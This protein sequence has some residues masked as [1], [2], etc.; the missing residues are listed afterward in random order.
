V[1]EPKTF[2]KNVRKLEAGTIEIFGLTNKYHSRNQYWRLEDFKQTNVDDAASVLRAKLDEVGALLVRADVP[3]GIALS[4]GVDSGIIAAITKNHGKDIQAFTVG[5]TGSHACDESDDA[6]R[7][8]RTLGITPHV[9]KLDPIQVG[10]KFASLCLLRDEPVADI[11]GAG[12]LAV[13][14]FARENGV[15][16]LLNG[17]GADELFWGYAW[18]RD[19][20]RKSNRRAKLLY[21]S[22]NFLS[23]F[24]PDMPPKGKGAFI[25]WVKSGAGLFENLKQL[26]E[27]LSDRRLGNREVLVYKRGPRARAK[28]RIIKTLVAKE[29]NKDY[30]KK[31]LLNSEVEVSDQVIHT[32]LETYLRSNGLGQM[33]R[34][35]MA[36]SI[37]ARTPLIDYKIVELALQANGKANSHKLKGKSLLLLA[38]DDLIPDEVKNRQKKASRHRLGNGTEK[39]I[40]FIK[41]TFKIQGLLNLGL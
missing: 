16:V 24:E 34:L 8:A 14:E 31:E 35:S 30:Y 22:S 20:A 41:T 21:G 4:S 2:I 37:E 12:Y 25:E 27:D 13:S 3:V 40:K 7:L 38:V 5:Y 15:K 11:A 6:V 1:P 28:N 39:F 17:Q 10:E 23:Y 9:V 36:A 18:V 29:F 19:A 32:L 33:D 26:G